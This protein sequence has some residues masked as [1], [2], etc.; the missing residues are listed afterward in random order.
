MCRLM[1]LGI[2]CL[3][4]AFGCAH[5][6]SSVNTPAT[7]FIEGQARVVSVDQVLGRAV[8]EIGGREVRAFWLTQSTT[9]QLRGAV[10][11]SGPVNSP[12][13]VYYEAAVQRQTFPAEPGDLIAFV[14]LR[15]GD[16]LFLRGVTVVAR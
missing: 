10:S 1:T 11:R 14:A 9:P 15:T 2:L 16:E 7:G 13:G 3:V 6:E 12:T 5:P 4:L 8:L